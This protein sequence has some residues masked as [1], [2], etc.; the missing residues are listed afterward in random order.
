VTVAV[1][2]ATGFLGG[3]L[4][5]QLSVAGTPVLAVGGPRHTVNSVSTSAKWL[6]YERDL[7]N[8]AR[9]IAEA[10]PDVVVHCATHYVLLHEP[11]DVEPMIEANVRLG[12]LILESLGG[13]GTQFINLS[14]YFQHQETTTGNP[15]S[16]YAATKSAFSLIAQWYG[17]NTKI[18]VSDITLFDTYGPGDQ[19]RKLIPRLLQCA[20]D[21]KT[22]DLRSATTPMNLC[23][24]DDVLAALFAVIHHRTIGAW[25]IRPSATVT[26]GEIARTVEEVT[27]RSLVT[28]WGDAESHAV[29]PSETP[30]D[31]PNWRPTVGLRDGITKCWAERR[32]HR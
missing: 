2:G 14:T 25:T 27:G 15:T 17:D 31:L 18:D 16:L 13:L 28:A 8:L 7:A 1:T 22:M 5:R 10:K 3:A 12:T 11:T 24:I 23:Y 21:G 26:V 6:P 29:L 32:G 19:R 30:P 20:L 4:V 9:T